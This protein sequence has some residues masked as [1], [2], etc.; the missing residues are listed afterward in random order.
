MT[1]QFVDVSDLQ[2]LGDMAELWSETYFH[3]EQPI[4]KI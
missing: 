1:Q 4:R 3:F 2:S